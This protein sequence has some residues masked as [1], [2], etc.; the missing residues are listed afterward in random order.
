VE[1][2]VQERHGPV[3]RRPEEGHKNDPRDGTLLLGGQAER[4]WAAHPGEEKAPGRAES[5]L[6]VS[7]GRLLERREQ[8]LQQGLL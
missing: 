6:S 7:K 2:S 5:S 1:S 8:T 4:A 3:G